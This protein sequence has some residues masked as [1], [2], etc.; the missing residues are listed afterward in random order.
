MQ[1]AA[2]I[3][4]RVLF[5]LAPLAIVLV[6]GFGLILRDEALRQ[7]VIDRVVGWLPVSDDGGDSVAMAITRLASPTSIVGLVPLATFF[8]AAGGMMAALRNGLEAALA[9]EE[10]RHAARG[11]LVD[12]A[13]VV[14]A[15]LLVI[16]TIA[17]SLV[18]QIVTSRVGGLAEATGL[19]NGLSDR[20]L[21]VVIPFAIA[22]PTVALLY[23]FVPSRRLRASATA[24]GAVV[25]SLLLV[26]IST[27]STLVFESTARLSAIYG[28]ITI[29][30]VFLYSVYRRHLVEPGTAFGAGD[31]SPDAARGDRLG[32]RAPPAEC[33]VLDDGRGG[34]PVSGVDPGRASRAPARRPQGGTVIGQTRRLIGAARA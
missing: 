25:T 24:A 32:V 26:G 6:F 8:W 29:V 20:A 4:Y 11:K 5:S 17:V 31:V 13:L 18:T 27:A 2:A 30:L 23:R 28:S 14:G 15:G 9:V 7:D 12:L 22:V 21:S 3:A 34:S 33:R 16:A 10:R 19:G 1:H